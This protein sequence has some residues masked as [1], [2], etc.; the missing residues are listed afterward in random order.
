MNGLFSGLTLFDADI[1]SWD[2]SG[3]TDMGNMFSVSSKPSNLHL[4][5]TLTNHDEQASPQTHH[6]PIICPSYAHR[7]PSVRQGAS[8][9]SQQLSF[10]TSSVTAMNNMFRVR[11]SRCLAP[12]LQ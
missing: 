7:M 8:A 1:S 10:N 9:F 12:K 5:S 11:S 3:V 6:I 2:T 4:D